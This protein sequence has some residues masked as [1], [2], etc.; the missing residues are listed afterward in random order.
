MQDF[1]AT[2]AATAI[3]GYVVLNV[4]RA[5]RALDCGRSTL[6][7]LIAEQRLEV[8]RI[9]GRPKI[10]ARSILKL[11]GFAAGNEPFGDG[12]PA[13]APTEAA[14]PRRRGRPPRYGAAKAPR[15]AA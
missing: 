3:D 11:L 14:Q 13:P 10:T 7:R 8:C 1:P 12:P 9:D 2:S 15:A 6:Y 4:Q 5:C